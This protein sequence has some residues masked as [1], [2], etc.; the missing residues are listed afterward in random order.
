M[1]WNQTIALVLRSG[2]EVDV[3]PTGY[4]LAVTN[5]L[6]F[7]Q[8][9]KE[10]KDDFGLSHNFNFHFPKSDVGVFS[11][12]QAEERIKGFLDDPDEKKLDFPPADQVYRSIL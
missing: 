9:A 5:Q 1:L 8:L 6:C 12:F 7:N 2:N 4:S 11:Y 10:G 3:D